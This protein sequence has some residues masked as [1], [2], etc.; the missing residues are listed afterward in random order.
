MAHDAA[1]VRL[2][3]AAV[4]RECPVIYHFQI[5]YAETHGT[6][7]ALQL[8]RHARTMAAVGNDFYESIQEFG[9]LRGMSDPR[10]PQPPCPN[11]GSPDCPNALLMRPVFVVPCEVE[12]SQ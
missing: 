7:P 6:V 11:C 2:H 3:A 1:F 10:E 8:I 9:R 5:Q 4:A 12:I